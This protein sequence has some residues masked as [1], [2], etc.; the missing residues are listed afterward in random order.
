MQTHARTSTVTAATKIAAKEDF[1]NIIA[2]EG[3]LSIVLMRWLPL[4]LLSQAL[5]LP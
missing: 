5:K 2:V 4:T 1:L 3:W